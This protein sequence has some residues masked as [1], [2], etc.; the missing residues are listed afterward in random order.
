MSTNEWTPRSPEELAAA[1]PPYL[2]ILDAAERTQSLVQQHHEQDGLI[3]VSISGGSDS[4]IMLD[5]FERI[6]YPDDLVY[7]AYFDTGMEYQA[8]KRHLDYLEGRYG[9]TIHRHRP[10]L[11]VAQAC[12]RYG[13][14]FFSK[15]VSQ[16][17]ESLQRHRFEWTEECHNGYLADEYFWNE[18]GRASASR[19]FAFKEYLMVHPPEFQISDRCC[20]WAKK[21]PSR[22]LE[23]ELGATLCCLGMRRAEG[24]V[25]SMTIHHCFHEPTA[26]SPVSRYY[27]IFWFTDEDK[28]VYEDWASIRHS[29]CYEK[30]GMKRTGCACCPFNSKFEE[31]LAIVEREEPKLYALANHVFGTSYA[32][33]RAYRQ[34][35]IDF[36][37]KKREEKANG[38]RSQ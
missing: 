13:V 21:K 3:I 37:Q 30:W 12:K 8:T 22:Q 6:G 31:D 25:R 20:S 10:K 14:P 24:G 38:H 29:D 5:L 1:F 4:D 19:N 11:T 26:S 35:K 36:R 28:A 15:R 32:Y 16:S 2:A 34:F 23:R 17:L 9:V 33:M 7:Y 18:S 27:P